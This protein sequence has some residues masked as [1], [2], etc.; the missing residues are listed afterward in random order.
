MCA[1]D[2]IHRGDLYYAV[3]YEKKGKSQRVVLNKTKTEPS[4]EERGAVQAER[5]GAVSSCSF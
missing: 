4:L 3:N 2:L 1:R 5:R